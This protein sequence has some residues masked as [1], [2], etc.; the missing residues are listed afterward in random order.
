MTKLKVSVL[1]GSRNRPIP[2]LKCLNSIL[3]QDYESIEIIVLDDSSDTCNLKDIVAKNFDDS[4]LHCYR[5]ESCLGVADGRNLLMQKASGDILIVLDDDAYFTE[6]NSITKIVDIFANNSQIG[7]VA[8]KIIDFGEQQEKLVL[9]F[10]KRSFKK[11]PELADRV[12]LVSYYVGCGHALLNQ[13]IETC[14]LYQENLVY[15]GEELDLSYR[16]IEAGF[17]IMYTP[18]VVIHHCPEASVVLNDNAKRKSGELFF[19]VRNRFFLAYKY[20]PLV[21][22]P[23]HLAIWTIKYALISIKKLSFR[24]FIS[25]TVAGIKG[26]GK[27]QRQ[28]L[29]KEATQYLKSHYGRLWY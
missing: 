4:R 23:I 18:D 24:E 6:N 17:Q 1:V 16:A 5:S 2:L 29:S 21:Y 15:G 11:H 10:S 9:P 19:H 25:G 7:V 14:G 20:L 26:L 22:I 28:P 12:Q 8:T 3:D 13:V 27:I